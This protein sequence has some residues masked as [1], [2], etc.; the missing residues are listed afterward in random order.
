MGSED[1]SPVIKLIRDSRR[2]MIS[3]MRDELGL[4][5]SIRPGTEI[6]PFAGTALEEKYAE[7]Q[8]DRFPGIWPFS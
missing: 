6:N 2:D 1:F 4:D 8:R 5:S 7:A 3:V